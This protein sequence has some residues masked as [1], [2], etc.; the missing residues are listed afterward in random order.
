MTG[1]GKT[2]SMKSAGTSCASP[3]V[4]MTRASR[5]CAALR[6][7][8]IWSWRRPRRIQGCKHC[9]MAA[10]R[11]RRSLSASA[12]KTPSRWRWS[13]RQLSENLHRRLVRPATH[14]PR[15]RHPPPSRPASHPL[16][17][18]PSRRR[19]LRRLFR[20]LLILQQRLW[21]LA[22]A[23]NLDSSKSTADPGGSDRSAR[24]RRGKAIGNDHKR[25]VVGGN[26]RV[27]PR[28]RRNRAG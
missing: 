27:R 10:C 2:D 26:S 21:R 1:D 28:R 6:K 15:Q 12:V 22:N 18:S 16:P 23:G 5:A 11:Q 25:R 8:A 9:A 4:V 7:S 3:P 24:H 14:P 20:N 19:Y 17:R 13:T